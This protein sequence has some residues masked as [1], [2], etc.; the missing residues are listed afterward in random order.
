MLTLTAPGGIGKTKLALH[1]AAWVVDQFAD[2]VFFVD[3]AALREA[4]QCC[5][6]SLPP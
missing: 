1:A 5:R 4:D 6:R 3:L 2:G